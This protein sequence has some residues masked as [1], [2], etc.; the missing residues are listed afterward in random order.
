[1]KGSKESRM[2]CKYFTRALFL[3]KIIELGLLWVGKVSGIQ[4]VP[5]QHLQLRILKIK[6]LNAININIYLSIDLTTFLLFCQYHKP[7]VSMMA[8][9]CRCAGCG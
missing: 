6:K 9:G 1:M 5:L 2:L 4:I 7:E 8:G 3:Q